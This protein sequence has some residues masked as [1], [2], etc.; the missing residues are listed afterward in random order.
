MNLDW[1]TLKTRVHDMTQ[2]NNIHPS[3]LQLSQS[4]RNQISIN[5]LMC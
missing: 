1:L 2:N 3:F 5:D 4:H